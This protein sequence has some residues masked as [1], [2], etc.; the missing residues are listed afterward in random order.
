MA[1][2]ARNPLPAR[3][4][5]AS[6]QLRPQVVAMQKQGVQ[7][8]LAQTDA[9]AGEAPARSPVRSAYTATLRV[10]AAAISQRVPAISK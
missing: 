10:S 4:T 9:A 8:L 2:N 7:M 1:L 3:S 5:K 6:K